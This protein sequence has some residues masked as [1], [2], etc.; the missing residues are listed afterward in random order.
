MLLGACAGI[1]SRAVA[2]GE[3]EHEVIN[4]LG[5]PSNIYKDGG[6]RLLEYKTG[7][8][9]QRTYMARIGPDGK[10][11]SY[12]QVLTDENFVRIEVGKATK[13]EVLRRIGSPSE[14]S[15]LH[16]KNLEVWS[17]PY[18]ESGTWNS[19][20]HVHIDQRGVVHSLLNTQDLRYDSDG[21]FPSMMMG[22]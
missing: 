18:K 7:P 4:K 11:D 9:G 15:Y 14:T 22:L 10:L 5:I 16:L 8:W 17:Y 3:P 1:G 21:L 13:D 20:M 19:V 6:S 2:V 12:E